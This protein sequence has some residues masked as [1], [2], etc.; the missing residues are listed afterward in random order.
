[1]S[2][3]MMDHTRSLPWQAL[4]LRAFLKWNQEKNCGVRETSVKEK[5]E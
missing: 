5:K 2:E 3:T 4:H 1:M